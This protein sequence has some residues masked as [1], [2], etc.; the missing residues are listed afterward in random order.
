MDDNATALLAPAHLVDLDVITSQAWNRRTAMMDPMPELLRVTAAAP[1]HRVTRLAFLHRIESGSLA[2]RLAGSQW[3]MLATAL[4][5][6]LSDEHLE[7][8]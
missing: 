5:Q 7:Q 8:R 2:A 4:L 6:Y 1:C 3:A